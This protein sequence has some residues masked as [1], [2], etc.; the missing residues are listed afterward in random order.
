[1]VTSK[2]TTLTLTLTLTLVLALALAACGPKVDPAAGEAA[3]A[4]LSSFNPLA[5]QDW[6]GERFDVAARFRAEM[7]ESPSTCEGDYDG[8]QMAGTIAVG[9]GRSTCTQEGADFV[10]DHRHPL[11][12]PEAEVRLRVPAM[13]RVCER[14]ANGQCRNWRTEP[15]FRTERREVPLK[16]SRLE[17]SPQPRFPGAREGTSW[18]TH[19]APFGGRRPSEPY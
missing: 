19:S 11:R 5:D 16:L 1:M 18:R 9:W 12:S 8:F 14:A 17:G 15:G 6:R 7:A 13:V 4:E 2:G 10:L 3:W